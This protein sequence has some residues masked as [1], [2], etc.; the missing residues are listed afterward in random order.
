MVIFSAIHPLQFFKGF[1]TS[2]VK[3]L[4]DSCWS[5]F[6]KIP[7]LGIEGSESGIGTPVRIF[8]NDDGCDDNDMVEG[9][10]ADLE[11]DTGI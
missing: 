9:I 7:S 11:I 3:F 1:F 8:E 6:L 2:I 5:I 4:N 10:E